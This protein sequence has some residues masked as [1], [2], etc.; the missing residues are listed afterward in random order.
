MHPSELTDRVYARHSPKSGNRTRPT[1][2][3]IID[4]HDSHKRENLRHID[5][6][7]TRQHNSF[8]LMNSRAEF[9][10]GSPESGN[11]TRPT[12]INIIDKHDSHK[13]ENLRH[14]DNQLTRQHN[15]F[16]L[17][18]SRAEFIQGTVPRVEIV[19]GLH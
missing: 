19:R 4:K 12:L 2:I 17:M 7:L 16:T 9:I 13:R 14:I 1:L 10:Q 3:N 8:T 15:S 5:N 11:R 6:Q 18:N